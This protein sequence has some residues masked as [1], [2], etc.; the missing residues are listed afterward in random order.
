MLKSDL[1]MFV[2]DDITARRTDRRKASRLDTIFPR[3]Q[4]H[5]GRKGRGEKHLHTQ[6]A[7]RI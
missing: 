5:K 4:I 6:K 3:L 7:L 2:T 1:V